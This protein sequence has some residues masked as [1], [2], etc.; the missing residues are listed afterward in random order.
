MAAQT[1]MVMNTPAKMKNNPMLLTIGKA[2]LA[3]STMEVH[4]QVTIR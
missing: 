4:I 1:T 3:K 2:L